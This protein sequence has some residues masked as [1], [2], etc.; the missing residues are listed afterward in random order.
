[1]SVSPWMTRTRSSSQPSVSAVI[2][3]IAVSLPHPGEVTPVNTV[4]SPVGL[5]RSVVPS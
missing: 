4:T 5:T 2:C 1:M 3:A